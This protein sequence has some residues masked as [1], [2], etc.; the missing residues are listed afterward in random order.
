MKLPLLGSRAKLSWCSVAIWKN[1]TVVYLRS[2]SISVVI[3]LVCIASGQRF[4]NSLHAYGSLATPPSSPLYRQ[5]VLSNCE[6]NE[7]TGWLSMILKLPP[8]LMPVHL[9][10]IYKLLTSLAMQLLCDLEE[11]LVR[12][13]TVLGGACQG[14]LPRECQRHSS[15]KSLMGTLT[16]PS[17]CISLLYLSLLEADLC[18]NP[19]DRKGSGGWGG[20]G[21]GL[22]NLCPG[23][24]RKT[25]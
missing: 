2:R 18:T 13:L 23:R 1:K 7:E 16:I 17:S 15:K 9:K 10:F 4:P 11:L 8:S 24:V 3:L 5:P 19:H 12:L 14:G 20:S 25:R 22:Q 21:G 6:L